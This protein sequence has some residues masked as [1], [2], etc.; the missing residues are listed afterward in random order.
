MEEL[1]SALLCFSIYL[2]LS[3]SSSPPILLSSYARSLNAQHS[4]TTLSLHLPPQQYPLGIC[5]GSQSFTNLNPNPTHH[6][7]YLTN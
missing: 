3:S 1:F 6:I 5:S 7:Y 4:T 2:L